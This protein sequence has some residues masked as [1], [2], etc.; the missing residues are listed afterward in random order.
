MSDEEKAAPAAPAAKSRKPLIAIGVVA[1]LAIAGGGYFWKARSAAHPQD[2]A[3]HEVSKVDLYLPLEPA[4]VVNFKD[5][6]SLRYLQVSVTLM[7]H[8]QK[9]IDAAKG[10]D[11]EIRDALVSLFSNQDYAVI[12]T[13][14]GRRSL[15]DK[16]LA[17]VRKIVKAHTN[18]QSDIEALYFTSFVMQ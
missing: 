3:Q 13:P 2:Q 9:A 12:V 11:P 16:A 18:G 1:V 7:S 6:D 14:A 17:T 4:F 10:A 15:Q 5:G 8:D